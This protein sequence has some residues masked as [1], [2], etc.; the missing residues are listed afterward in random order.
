MEV[1]LAIR[2]KKVQTA[3]FVE[4]RTEGAILERH[5]LTAKVRSENKL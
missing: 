5:T 1:A 3:C 2:M 4:T